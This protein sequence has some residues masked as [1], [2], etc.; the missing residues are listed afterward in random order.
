M[1]MFQESQLSPERDHWNRAMCEEIKVMNSREVWTLVDLPPGSKVIGSKWV[2]TIQTD[3]KNNIRKFKA[4][5]VAQGFNQRFGIDY[6]DVFSPVINFSLIRFFFILFVSV[7]LWEHRQ[8]D[9]KS[10][11]LYGKLQE[12][13][14]MKQPKGFEIPGKEDKVCLL[15]R[16]I[17][18]LHESGKEWYNEIESIL[19]IRLCKIKLV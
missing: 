3:D 18:G 12:K 15:L 17:Y 9:V 13:N 11:Y 5:L 10:A 7:L 4:R 1:K 14:Y 19:V 8:L 16:A 2:Y 6:N